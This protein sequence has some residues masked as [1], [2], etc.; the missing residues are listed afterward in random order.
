[1]HQ[2]LR[3]DRNLVAK[4]GGH[5]VCV[6][7]AADVPQQRDPINSVAQ[8]LLVS[9]SLADPG[10]EQAGPELGLQRLAERIVLRQGQGG[11]EFA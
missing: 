4:D 7:G 5:F 2:R 9:G 8:L 3:P 6:T 10:S 11:D 1:M